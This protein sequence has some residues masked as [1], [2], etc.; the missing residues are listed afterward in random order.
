MV[1]FQTGNI[2]VWKRPISPRGSFAIAFLNFLIN[3]G[4]AKEVQTTL[5]KLGLNRTSGYNITEGF[6][7][8]FIGMYKPTSTLSV[9]V[10]PSGVY[11]V[12]AKPLS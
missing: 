12:V 9:M 7:G 8:E 11:L 10:N 2:Q 1:L 4:G 6:T 5:H 3:G